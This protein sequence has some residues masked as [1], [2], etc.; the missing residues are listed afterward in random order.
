MVRQFDCPETGCGFIQGIHLPASPFD[1][2][3]VHPKGLI[4]DAVYRFDNPET[5]Q[6]L[7]RTGA[8]LSTEG[9]IVELPRRTGVIWFYQKKN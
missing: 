5:D 9:I 7:E 6:T 2:L 1:S 4:P 3:V 8:A